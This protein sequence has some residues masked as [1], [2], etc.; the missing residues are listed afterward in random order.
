MRKSLDIVKNKKLEPDFEPSIK[1]IA[2]IFKT[3][4][5]N[6][7]GKKTSLCIDVDMNYT[8]LAKNIVWLETKDIV[9]S[10]IK[11]SIINVTLTKKGKE[12]ASVF[13]ED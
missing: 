3:I 2:G 7:W 10:K 1:T 4:L 8:R 6:R 5:S 9:K 12:L 13:L 11:A